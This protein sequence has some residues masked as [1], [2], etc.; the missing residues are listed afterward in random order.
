VCAAVAEAQQL[1]DDAPAITSQTSVADLRVLSTGL[2][3]AAESVVV[4]AVDGEAATSA[5]AEGLTN[6]VGTLESLVEA[7]NGTTVGS[8]GANTVNAALRDVGTAIGD[9]SVAA[10]CE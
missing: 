9:V 2:N 6:A 8:G 5:A 3:A 4:V 10:T 7:F 1:V